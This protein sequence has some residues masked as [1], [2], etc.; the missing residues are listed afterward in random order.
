MKR[1]EHFIETIIFWSRW[2][3][4]VLYLGLIVASVLYSYKF[5]V[6]LLHLVSHIGILSESA[7]M[8]AVLTLV[9]FTMVANLLFMVIVGGYST[10]VSKINVISRHEDRPE[11]LDKVSAGT[12]KVKLAGSLVGVSGIHL[13]QTF[14]TLSNHTRDDVIFQILIHLV[15]LVSTVVLAY[16]EK[17]LHK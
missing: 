10:F 14:I 6:E 17:I 2:L 3:Q 4:V 9:D 7:V 5:L 16:S 1:L 12:L 8:M 13:L 11:W 15:F